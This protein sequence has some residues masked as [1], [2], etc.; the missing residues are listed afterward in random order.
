MSESQQIGETKLNEPAL[1]LCDNVHNLPQS[2]PEATQLSVLSSLPN[3]DSGIGDHIN[4]SSCVRPYNRDPVNSVMKRDVPSACGALE[5]DNCRDRLI[6]LA[7]APQVYEVPKSGFSGE[8]KVERFEIDEARLLQEEL[9]L[10]AEELRLQRRRLELKKRL[11]T[12]NK[13]PESLSSASAGVRPP[14][15]LDSPR[16]SSTYSHAPAGRIED[17]LASLML[18]IGLPNLEVV[19]F[20]GSP[21]KFFAFIRSFEG[22]IAN[23]LRDDSQKLSYLINYCSGPARELIEHCV[24]LPEEFRY[25]QAIGILRDRFGRPHQVMESLAN[26]YLMGLG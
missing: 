4:L 11:M 3:F 26:E 6:H 20:D 22:A 17:S 15:R 7:R 14:S 21:T 16:K 24:L 25:R 5:A 1:E 9:E 12:Q 2:F 13:D 10:D 23:R 8:H 19:K 18:G